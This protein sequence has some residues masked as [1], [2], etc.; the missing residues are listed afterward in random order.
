[1]NG[2]QFRKPCFL[3]VLYVHYAKAFACVLFIYWEAPGI[4]IMLSAVSVKREQAAIHLVGWN[5]VLP[6]GTTHLLAPSTTRCALST[7]H[8][9]V[10]CCDGTKP[11]GHW[12]NLLCGACM[13]NH[14]HHLHC[15]A[16]GHQKEKK[17]WGVITIYL[18][19]FKFMN[20]QHLE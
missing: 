15:S 19:V 20:L 12:K 5:L 17:E 2:K 6:A 3:K 4:T 10:L 9:M 1:M 16:Y 13:L 7:V 11:G 18:N 14:A 8:T